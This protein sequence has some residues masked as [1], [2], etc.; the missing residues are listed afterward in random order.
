MPPYTITPAVIAVCRCDLVLFHYSPVS[1]CMAPLQVEASM[2]GVKGS[3][4]N[5]RYDPKCPSARCLRMVHED[6]GA[7]SVGA[8]YAS[9]EPDETFDRTCAIYTMWRSV[10]EVLSL[11]FV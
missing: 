8:A 3:T 1:S 6:T 4:R 9:I 7:P 10:D 11:V 5:G 2:G